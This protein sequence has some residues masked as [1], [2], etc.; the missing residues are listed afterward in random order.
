MKRIVRGLLSILSFKILTLVIGIIL[1]PV[2]VRLLGSS[3]YGDYAFLI[4]FYTVVLIFTK[5][6]IDNGLRKYINEN[7][8]IK[9]W[10][11]LVFGFYF[12]LSIIFAIC[13]VGVIYLLSVMGVFSYLNNEWVNEYI[14]IIC[15][16]IF[17]SQMASVFKSGLMGLQLEH[18]SEPIKAVRKIT[19]G[20]AAVTLIYL[21]LGVSGALIGHVIG[22][23]V[24]TAIAF[25]L[26][27]RYIKLGNLRYRTP[28]S[29]S[30]RKLLSY[31]FHA[32]IFSLLMTSLYQVDILLLRPIAG[33]QQTGYYR[34]A[35]SIGEFLWFVPIAVQTLFLYSLS[36][37]WKKNEVKKI[38]RI[39]SRAARYVLLFTVLLAMGLAS[40][41]DVFVPLYFGTDFT[42][43][44]TP[45]LLLLPG[46]VLF[47]MARPV[48]G[49]SQAKSVQAYKILIYATFASAVI[50]LVLNLILIPEFGM[51]GAAVATSIGY[52]LMVVF[53]FIGARTIGFN[54]L[55]DLRLIRVGATSLVTGVVIF[56]VEGLIQSDIHSLILI[57][58]LGFVSLII[59]AYIMGA[60]D[61]EELNGI[62][63]QVY[64][65]LG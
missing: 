38:S 49:A 44:V 60:V 20:I 51:Y 45:L 50:N 56:G 3:N 34:A 5:G 8:D 62:Y 39:S 58:P 63:N 11:S 57:P 6:G 30:R 54:P 27:R 13:A 53:H 24:A 7:R 1:T 55:T 17:L 35:L 15:V 2:L 61:S 59:F 40:L 48:Y 26:L 25:I 65:I 23:L 37:M 43:S 28:S 46:I 14:L 9:N 52:G 22:A 36:D 4:S 16:L 10:K 32:V 33:S 64:D 19:F 41:G 47:S 31:N 29:I 21:G 12:K 42:A 18:F